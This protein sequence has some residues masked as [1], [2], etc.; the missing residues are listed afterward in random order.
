MSRRGFHSIETAA[1]AAQQAMASGRHA[2]AERAF[3]E[4]IAQTHVVDY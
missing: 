1:S 4:L 3:R 2:E